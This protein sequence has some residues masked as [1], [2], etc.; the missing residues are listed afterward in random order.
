MGIPDYISF[1]FSIDPKKGM[2]ASTTASFTVGGDYLFPS[3][4]AF[5]IY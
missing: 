3:F 4:A 5:S 2:M 1:S